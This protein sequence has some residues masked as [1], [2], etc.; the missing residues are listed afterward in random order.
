[1]FGVMFT[2]NAQNNLNYISN[3]PVKHKQL[4]KQQLI[5]KYG[6]QNK[7]YI[8][9]ILEGKIVI[10]MTYAMCEDALYD[11]FNYV[12]FDTP[13]DGTQSMALAFEISDVYKY[14]YLEFEK[15][16]KFNKKYDNYKN[17]KLIQIN[18]DWNETVDTLTNL[19]FYLLRN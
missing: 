7:K 19:E 16:G 3:M 10:G 18:T 8:N 6:A 1:M 15:K 2:T 4:S 13:T 14:P 11:Y 9:Y 12:V 5:K 17:A